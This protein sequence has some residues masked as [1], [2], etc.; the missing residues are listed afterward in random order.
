MVHIGSR[1]QGGPLKALPRLEGQCSGML[2]QESPM[3]TKNCNDRLGR[4]RVL[5]RGNRYPYSLKHMDYNAYP[6][7]LV[8][9]SMLMRSPHEYF[10]LDEEYYHAIYS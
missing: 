2:L 8:S 3:E 4:L 6:R 10:V 5:S 7:V 9:N 1:G